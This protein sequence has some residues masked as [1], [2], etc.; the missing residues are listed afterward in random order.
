[1]MVNRS[2]MPLTPSSERT[3]RATRTRTRSGC[4]PCRNRRRKCDETR[5]RCQNCDACG[6]ECRWGIKVSFHPSR[7]LHLSSEDSTLLLAIENERTANEPN[8]A[9][10]TVGCR[11]IDDTET[12]RQYY[13]DSSPH[14]PSPPPES[15]EELPFVDD[16]TPADYA[17]HA[18][19]IPTPRSVNLAHVVFAEGFQFLDASPNYQEPSPCTIIGSQQTYTEHNS[20][21]N[22][23]PF[24]LGQGISRNASPLPELVLPISKSE[25]AYIMAAYLR[26]T[27]TWCETTDSEM[28]FTVKS[29]HPMMKSNAFAAA[30]LALSSRQ[31]DTLK[32]HPQKKTLEL[33][34]YTIQHLI[35][36]DPAEAD[37][38]VLAACT[39]LC[40][41]EMMA[42]S[43]SEWRR[44]LKGCAGLLKSRG[45][46]GSSTGIVKAC[47]WA[48]AR[49]DIWAA[50]II[51]ETTLIP[52]EC[53][54]KNDSVLS[55]AA[56]GDIDDYCNLAILVFAKTVNMLASNTSL[57]TLGS[58]RT[59][60]A[61]SL[62]DYIQ[63][64]RDNR[65]TEVQP[66][67]RAHSGVS[68]PF[69]ITTFTRSAAI[70]GNTF[71]HACA[72]LL[73]QTGLVSHSTSAESEL[74]DPLWHAREIGGISTWNISHANWVNHLQPL[75]I[76]GR[77]FATTPSS[78]SQQGS[79][80]H[81]CADEYAPEKIALLKQLARIEKETGWKTSDR[82]QELRNL[83]GLG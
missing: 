65:P 9:S 64:W 69:P 58:R 13:R 82:S 16:N 25:Q 75:Y 48:F 10:V 4:L 44:H 53:W 21:S 2:I 39:L 7:A 78:A 61:D 19:P 24:S 36:Q 6:D 67:L 40:V 60:I 74:S 62:W 12:I 27:G 52:T 79:G 47:F 20:P 83:W 35:Q 8:V 46:H 15:E 34:Q 23:P 63:Q 38:S 22:L 43:V 59:K 5:P 72:I 56:T 30:A 54:V 3:R 66:L 70:C 73:L 1:M 14:S 51:G 17:S 11:I 57:G 18:A 33:Y 77:A 26:E 81:G 76:A 80:F 45:W 68:G 37:T 31:L 71:Y 55:V 41:Y 29:I 32:G 42:S 49:I 50:F 28:H